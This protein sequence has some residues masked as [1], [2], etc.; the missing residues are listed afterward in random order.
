M[1]NIVLFC[2]GGM[3]TSLLVKK[4]RDEAD[5]LGMDCTIN[6]Y[7]LAETDTYAPDADL[8]LLG[9][10]VRYALTKI[11]E[12]YPDKTVETID[13]RA[14]GMMDGKTVLNTALKLMGEK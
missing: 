2:A 8:I 1:K 6:A 10:Q 12:N 5:V 14:Y 9:P 13:M 7:G 4:M 3:S 11:Q